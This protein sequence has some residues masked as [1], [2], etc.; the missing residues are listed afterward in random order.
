MKKTTKIII[1]SIGAFLFG[2]SFFLGYL[3]LQDT[4]FNGLDLMVIAT[5]LVGA[6]FLFGTEESLMSWRFYEDYDVSNDE[7]DNDDE[8]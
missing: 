1:R 4:I 2:L 8:Q 6:Y 7:N 3:S 5:Y